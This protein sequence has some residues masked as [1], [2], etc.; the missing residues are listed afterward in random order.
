MRTL[1]AFS[2]FW[3]CDRSFWLWTTMPVGQV[4]QA[5]GRVGLVDV[6]AA[7][8]LR[9]ER[10]DPDLVPVELDLDVVVDLGQDLDQGERR[11]APL[12][13]VERADADEPMDAALGA[14]PAVRPPPIDLD[15]HALEA[16]LLALLLVDDLGREAMALGPAQVHAQEH[17]GPVGR[18]GAAG[19]GADR[20]DRRRARRAR[21]R[22]GARSARARSRSRARRHRGRARPRARRRRLRRASSSGGLEVVG[23]RQQVL[24]GLDLGAQAVGLAQD[25]LGA[26]LVVPEAG[27]LGQRL[28]LGDARLLWPRG[29]RRPEV[30]RIRSA[31]S[32]MADAST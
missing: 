29:Q 11:L 1:I 24:P 25:L 8:A 6:L 15:G 9:A 14:Q 26:A 23:A 16:G 17:L 19:A 12:L 7:G 27:F 10:V 20:Q 30:D 3:V 28:E 32:R 4:G 22:T 2:L 21:R 18:L 5:H 13:R 31:R